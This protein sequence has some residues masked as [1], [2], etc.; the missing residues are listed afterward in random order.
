[1]MEL[2]NYEI[3]VVGLIKII[4]REKYEVV[5]EQLRVNGGWGGFRLSIIRLKFKIVSKLL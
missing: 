3:C 5:A 4:D 1:M 2:W